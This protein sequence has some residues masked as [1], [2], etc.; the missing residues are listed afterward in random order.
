MEHL[1]VGDGIAL[2][3]TV[4]TVALTFIKIYTWRKSNK[5]DDFIQISTLNGRYVSKELFHMYSK[6]VDKT[7]TEIKDL[8]KELAEKNK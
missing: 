7:L 2:G 4:I 6:H 1:T 5:D 8:L 3:V